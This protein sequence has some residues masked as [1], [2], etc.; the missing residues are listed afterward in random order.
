MNNNS[1]RIVAQDAARWYFSHLDPFDS[2]ESNI[3]NYLRRPLVA[4]TVKTLQKEPENGENNAPA[5]KTGKG[6]DWRDYIEDGGDNNDGKNQTLLQEEFASLSRRIKARMEGFLAG[7]SLAVPGPGDPAFASKLEEEAVEPAARENDDILSLQDGLSGFGIAKPK[8]FSSG[9]SASLTMKMGRTMIGETADPNRVK[10][11]QIAREDLVVR[12]DI[13]IRTLQRLKNH[14][15]ECVI[16]M[17]PSKLIRA[18][19]RYTTNAFVATATY[20]RNIGRVL[21]RLLHCLTMEMLAV[22]CVSEELTKIFHRVSSEYEHQTSFAS[23]AFLSTPEVNADAVLTPLIIKFLRHL[24]ADWERLVRECE[25]ERVIT[26]SIDP[27]MRKMFKTVE[28][29][30]IGHLLEVCHAHRGKLQS[31]ELPPNMCT[32]AENVGNLWNSTD[33]IRQAFRD[34]RREI[35][36]VNGQV[37]PPVTSRKEL[38]SMLTQTLNS[39]TLTF[40]IGRKKRGAFRKSKYR[41]RGGPSAGYTDS[42][43]S[44]DGTSSNDRQQQSFHDKNGLKKTHPRA[45]KKETTKTTDVV[46]DISEHESSILS[47]SECESSLAMESPVEDAVR[48]N[49]AGTPTRGRRRHK[50]KLHL[51]AI[52]T[53]TR[54][55]LI[56]GSRTGNGG[57]A[58]FFVKDLFGGEDVEV[59]PTSMVAYRDRMVHPGTI[60][61]LVRLASVTIRCHQSFDIYPKSL[62]GETE[63]LIQFHTTTTE[64]ISLREVHADEGGRYGKDATPDDRT[65]ADGS[66]DEEQPSLM[67]IQEQQTDRTGW[68]VIS[69]R[70][71]MYEK[72][73]T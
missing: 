53:L 51:S 30:S 47:A 49:K 37:L 10:H 19:A 14:K 65:S 38:L 31:I 8:S 3:H 57:D 70:P 72:I 42:E 73:E 20:V 4:L 11:P 29:R 6:G 33:A 61:I 62:I 5:D 39:R 68:R 32:T 36:T 7:C 22:E 59:I 54:R 23:L 43:A 41:P 52:D 60:D 26:R 24:Q 17:E 64:S 71:A 69:I 66:D 67:V 58:Y 56:A 16:A 13:Y 46:S 2:N 15:K 44:S 25:L 27:S 35:I 12:L 45:A 28:F 63:P 50:S 40:P 9:R 34:L 55:L 21:T 18:R 1:T 48:A